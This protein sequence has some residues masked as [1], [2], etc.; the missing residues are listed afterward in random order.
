M[1]D[2]SWLMLLLQMALV[3]P[4]AIV[5]AWAL[6]RSGVPGGAW[7]GGALG[8]LIAAVLIGPAIMGRATPEFHDRVFVGAVAET[9]ALDEA[10]R[11]QRVRLAALRATD[12]S[13][14]A[15][16]EAMRGFERE[17]RPLRKARAEAMERHRRQSW[18][19]ITGLAALHACLGVMT[20][21]PAG[22]R[23]WSRAG[24]SVWAQRARPVGAGAMAL[25]IASAPVAAAFALAPG[26]TGPALVAS[27]LVFAVPACSPTMRGPMFVAGLTAFVAGGLLFMGVTPTIGMFA[28][29]TLAAFGAM[30]VLG[31]PGAV[32]SARRLIGGFMAAVTLPV[33]LG[34]AGSHVDPTRWT[35]VG[36]AWGYLTP[37]L[38]A[39][40]WASDGRWSALAIGAK[41]L[42]VRTGAYWTGAAR[43]VNAGSGSVELVLAV[44]AYSAGMF[45]DRV[46]GAALVGVVVIEMT[47]RVRPA[48]G[49]MLDSR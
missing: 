11:E 25:L 40:L 28:V 14:V 7:G 19:L 35:L 6:R 20:M 43:Q 34:M 33:L 32:R 31:W 30:M 13:E 18:W 49:R 46:L 16:D 22:G 27:T 15:I 44:V 47:R 36:S 45:D 4:L 10:G 3:A 37:L 9:M 24:R 41:F 2:P 5:L 48:I 29:V 39:V 8:G 42:R 12:V 17:L 1:N 23:A 26:L 38:V 21:L